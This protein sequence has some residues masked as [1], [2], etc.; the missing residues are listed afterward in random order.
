MCRFHDTY[1]VYLSAIKIWC[2]LIF[3]IIINWTT[4]TFIQSLLT[5]PTQPQIHIKA[6][7]SNLQRTSINCASLLKLTWRI[8]MQYNVNIP[9]YFYYFMF[10]FLNSIIWTL[11]VI[12]HCIG[13]FVGVP[14]FFLYLFYLRAFYI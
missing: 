6:V 11:M 9:F 12:G 1:Y 4:Q 2:N 5:S 10:L 8:N 14:F 13:N 3:S 7:N